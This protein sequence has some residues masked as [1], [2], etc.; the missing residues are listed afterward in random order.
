MAKTEND[1]AYEDGLKAGK[2]GNLLTDLGKTA[3]FTITSRAEIWNK[4]YDEGA[5]HRGEESSVEETSSNDSSSS[6][7]SSCYL[8]TAC[9]T[10]MGL[11]NNC[12]ELQVLR[13]FR[14]KILMSTSKG[15]KAV[16]EYHKL[17]PEIVQSIDGRGN[18]E[19][20]W[21]QIYTDIRHA[22]SLVLN[23]NFEGAF[24]HYKQVTLNLKEKYLS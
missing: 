8:T 10:A 13:E 14:N 17:A 24:K 16:Q 21:K 11:P 23:N 3:A 6:S 20:I 7:D 19:F 22:V 15:R 12:L 2:E 18:A 1:K 9:V 5:R 4:G